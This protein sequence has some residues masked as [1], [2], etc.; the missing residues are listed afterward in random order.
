MLWKTKFTHLNSTH[1]IHFDYNNTMIHKGQ[2]IDIFIPCLVDYFMPE[3]GLAMVK[4]LEYSGFSVRYDMRQKCCGQPFFNAGF[5]KL[6]L[7][8]ALDFIKL[9]KNADYIILPSGSCTGMIKIHYPELLNGNTNLNFYN[10]KDK[11]YELSEFLIDVA[12]IE[13]FK[14][15]NTGRVYYHS[16]C[17]LMR[18]IGVENQPKKLLSLIHGIDLIEADSIKEC[19]GFGGVFCIK[20]SELSEDITKRTLERILKEQVDIIIANDAGCILAM[21][22]MLHNM[23][24][25]LKKPK[26][27]HLSQFLWESVQNSD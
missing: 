1:K 20:F 5:K 15:K 19:C 22:S 27:M 4:L 8:F 18:E 2:T 13:N 24:N 26:I 6:A 11:V 3:I 7:P 17:H 25:N 12:K 16:S 21:R 23:N 9:F 14:G 10:L